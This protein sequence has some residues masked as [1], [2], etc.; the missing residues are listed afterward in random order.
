VSA[1]ASAAV[2][3]AIESAPISSPA[4]ATVPAPTLSR[5]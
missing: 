3:A 4:A 2:L 1:I 5:S